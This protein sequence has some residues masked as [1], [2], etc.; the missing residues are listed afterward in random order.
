MWISRALHQ[1]LGMLVLL[2]SCAGLTASAPNKAIRAT[3]NT[4]LACLFSIDGGSP[5]PAEPATP[6]TV[7]ITL[8]EH[9][10]TAVSTDGQDD[11]TGSVT[12]VGSHANFLIP[13]LEARAERVEKQS[14]LLALKDQL[15]KTQKEV[16][17]ARNRNA[18]FRIEVTDTDRLVTDITQLEK[19]FAVEDSIANRYKKLVS[20]LSSSARPSQGTAAAVASLLQTALLVNASQNA[21]LHSERSGQIL[22]CIGELTNELGGGATS[23]SRFMPEVCSM[24]ETRRFSINHTPFMSG[25]WHGGE[26]RISTDRIEWVEADRRKDNFTVTCADVKGLGTVHGLFSV[27]DDLVQGDEFYIAEKKRRYSFHSVDRAGREMIL[28]ALRTACPSLK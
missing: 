28:D 7:Q 13:L 15:L 3:V 17:S 9:S 27:V 24:D 22:T 1:Y 20:D 12:A 21:K 4:D 19:K 5:V 10:V 8:G 25:R 23:V 26:L 18:T 11:W 16:E 14:R 2:L 6:A